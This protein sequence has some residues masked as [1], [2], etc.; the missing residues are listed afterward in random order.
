MPNDNKPTRSRRT[1]RNVAPVLVIPTDPGD[2]LT[3]A[4]STTP[5]S[6]S[7]E[8]PPSP[9]QRVRDAEGLLKA[10]VR[11]VDIYFTTPEGATPDQLDS[12]GRVLVAGA[13]AYRKAAE[14]LTGR[15]IED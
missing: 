15:N 7:P 2:R 13:I 14:W 3:R 11:I 6:E 4:R 5:K 12:V 8:L 10:A 9:M 1:S